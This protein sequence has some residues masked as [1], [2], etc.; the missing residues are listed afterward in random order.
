M[1]L[2]KKM[3]TAIV[4][5]MTLFMTAGAAIAEEAKK[6]LMVIS[7]NGQDEGKTAPGYEFEEFSHAYLI[8]KANGLSVDIASPKGGEPVADRYD[9]KD[10]IIAKILSDGEV[11]AKLT[12]TIPLSEINAAE[13]G[14]VF[15]VGGKGAMF[16]FHDNQHLQSI[17]SKVYSSGGTVSAVCHG[18]AALVNV[19]LEDGSYLVAG[20]KVNGFTNLEEKMFGKK[21]MKDFEFMLEDELQ[22]RGGVFQSSPMMLSHVATDG[23]LITGQNPA[24]TPKVAEEVVRS[25]GLTPVARTVEKDERTLDMVQAVFSQ[26]IKATAP[27]LENKEA[28]NGALISTYGFY[29]SMTAETKEDQSLAVD[30][31]N[32]KTEMSNHHRLR[33]QVAQTLNKLGRTQ[34]ASE[35]AQ[36]ILVKKPDFKEAQAFLDSLAK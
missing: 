2:K 27:Y 15:V 23:R 25:M 17:I 30:L 16:D 5:V 10:L 19:K 31:M 32:V 8:F 29:F 3:I 7:S 24:S 1:T 28:Y 33:L 20:K 11:M 21:W 4:S 26:G 9:P 6:V 13:Y 14:G 22:A 36:A 34:E 12:D 18:P 35:V